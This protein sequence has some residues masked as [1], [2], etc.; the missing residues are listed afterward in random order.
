MTELV[1][2]EVSSDK[3]SLSRSCNIKINN[4]RIT[5]PNRAIGVTSTKKIEL[6]AVAP[7][8]GGKNAT[9][10]EA[11][12][13]L[14][15][16]ILASIVDNK[17]KKGTTYKNGDKLGENFS[18][19]MALRLS[20]LKEAGC[21]PYL[22]IQFT[23]ENGNPYNKLPSDDVL[24]LLFD[25]LW[26]TKDNSII[27]PP[28]MGALSSEK[29][30]IQFISQLEARK[31]S[32]IDRR[33]LPVIAVI[34]PVYRLVAPNI[35]EKYWQMGCRIFAVDLENK[36]LGAYGFI[37]ERLRSTLSELSKNDKE[38]YALHALNSKQRIGRGGS[39]RTNELLAPGYGFDFFG[40]AHYSRQRWIP[41][42]KPI[43]AVKSNYLFDTETYG[44]FPFSCLEERSSAKKFL[45][46]KALQELDLSDLSA[47][48]PDE[49]KN[50]CVKHNI[51]KEIKEVQ[52]YANTINSDELLTYYTTKARV[53]DDIMEM[54][55]MADKSHAAS[56]QVGLDQWFA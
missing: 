33:D 6:D 31:K 18:T 56:K 43:P 46:S 50:A 35:V 22:I 29:E 10:G 51:V 4:T 26:G 32:C 5:T 13:R 36:K 42:G 37:I 52:N 20:Q 21:V 55:S 53:K 2:E 8:L 14:S 49:I 38:P 17:R 45:D 39:M 44:F 34:P 7:Y 25:F 41:E 9:F 1:I 19:K 24:N 23:D 16:D 40:P 28:L 11:Y 30:Y 3:K 48:K 15:I 27:V 54:A 12:G 47:L